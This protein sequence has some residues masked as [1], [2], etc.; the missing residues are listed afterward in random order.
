MR[1]PMDGVAGEMIM[2]GGGRG[3]GSRLRTAFCAVTKAAGHE[4]AAAYTPP[5]RV[6]VSSSQSI[7]PRK[8]KM[9]ADGLTGALQAPT[10]GHR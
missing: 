4:E 9:G 2:A 5:Q 8:I 10:V 1:I 6:R 3:K 7:T